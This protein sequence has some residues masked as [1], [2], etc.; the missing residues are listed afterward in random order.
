[1]KMEL[2]ING[3]QKIF[4]VPFAPMLARR[5]YYEWKAKSEGIEDLAMTAQQVLDDDDEVLS[6]LPDV[7]FEKQFTLDEMYAGASEP[8]I[9]AKLKEAVFNIKPSEEED[10]GNDQ[11][12]Q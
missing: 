1:M 6:I 12:K 11:G 9:Q 3:E 8:Y 2:R 4:T 5:K 7:V 10:Q